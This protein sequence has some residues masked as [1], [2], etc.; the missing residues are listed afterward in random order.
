MISFVKDH[1]LCI[2]YCFMKQNHCDAIICYNY[3]Y[4]HCSL[5]K[6]GVHVMLYTDLGKNEYKHENKC[7]DTCSEQN[8]S[9]IF[10]TVD[11][12]PCVFTANGTRSIWNHH[13]VY[14][15]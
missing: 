7:Q 14:Q 10:T 13:D 12:K 11:L 1:G 15:T 4:Y 2:A 6:L 9:M 3:C 5:A 8:L